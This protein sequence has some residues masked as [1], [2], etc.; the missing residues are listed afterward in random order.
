MKCL[1]HRPWLQHCC[2]CCLKG[3]ENARVLGREQRQNKT[4]LLQLL[5]GCLTTVVLL[6]FLFEMASYDTATMIVGIVSHLLEFLSWKDFKVNLLE[7]TSETFLGTG[8]S[9]LQA[10]TQL[11]HIFWQANEAMGF[12]VRVG[13]FAELQ[14][15]SSQ[16]VMSPSRFPHPCPVSHQSPSQKQ[17]IGPSWLLC[18]QQHLCVAV[19]IR[20]GSATF[21]EIE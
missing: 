10:S 13:R 16:A 3:G 2:H 1:A 19:T 4:N 21:S 8:N 20:S 18:R 12:R 7:I 14:K 17:L 15:R 6:F 9:G 5:R 11:Q